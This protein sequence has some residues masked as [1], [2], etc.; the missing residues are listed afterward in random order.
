ME[1][2]KGYVGNDPTYE[3]YDQAEAAINAVTD[4]FGPMNAEQRAKFCRLS[5]RQRDDGTFTTNYDPKIAWLFKETEIVEDVDMWALWPLIQCPVLVM[6]GAESDLLS[7]ATAARMAA[8]GPKAEVY[9]VPGVGHAPALM[10]AAEIARI[11]AFLET[12]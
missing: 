7:A 9:E 5:I 11:V 1:R 2:I 3:T 8:E 10:T 4:K 6:R 12:P